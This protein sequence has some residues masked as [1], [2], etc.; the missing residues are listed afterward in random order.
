MNVVLVHAIHGAKVATHESEVQQD[1][2]NGWTR[3]NPEKAVENLVVDAPVEELPAKRKYNRK[4]TDQTN[5]IPSFM[6]SV[7]DKPEG[8]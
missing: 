5:E 6:S 2:K 3:Y 1:E 7:S 4:A 8:D